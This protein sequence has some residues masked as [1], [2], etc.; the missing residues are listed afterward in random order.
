MA[1]APAHARNP[2]PLLLVLLVLFVFIVLP[3]MVVALFGGTP[4]VEDGIPD[5][6]I[7]PVN[8]PYSAGGAL[9]FTV[10]WQ[11]RG[12]APAATAAYF[13][14]APAIGEFTPATA[15]ESAGYLGS[16]PGAEVTL[17]GDVKVHE[18]KIPNV[19][20]PLHVRFYASIDG[21]HYWSPEFEVLNE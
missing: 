4:P 2:K 6:G 5:V 20:S 18:A 21:K 1:D 7:L 9:E 12:G 11:V 17:G 14:D 16:A 19:F 13:S 15:P 8:V 3:I 10:Q